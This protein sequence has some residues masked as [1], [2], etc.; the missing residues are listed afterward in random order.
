MYL[1]A[2]A[3]RDLKTQKQK[4]KHKKQKETQEQPLI[5]CLVPLEDN[6][7]RKWGEGWI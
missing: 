1:E 4:Q 6:D 7:P 2:R 3:D 5:F